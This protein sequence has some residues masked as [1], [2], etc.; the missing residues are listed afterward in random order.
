MRM[1]KKSLRTKSRSL[2]MKSKSLRVTT[3]TA[4]LYMRCDIVG[5]SSEKKLRG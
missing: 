2:R 5:L 1:K 4:F 3:R